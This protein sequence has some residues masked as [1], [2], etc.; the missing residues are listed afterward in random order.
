MALT[1]ATPRDV[2]RAPT[3]PR[4]LDDRGIGPR[5]EAALFAISCLSW[6]FPGSALG[7]RYPSLSHRAS[8]YARERSRLSRL[9]GQGVL[10]RVSGHRPRRTVYG[11]GDSYWPTGARG[12]SP[13][14]DLAVAWGWVRRQGGP[15]GT[16]GRARPGSRDL[17]GRGAR[18]PRVSG[19][20]R[21]RPELGLGFRLPGRAVGGERPGRATGLSGCAAGH[22]CGRRGRS[23]PGERAAALPGG[24][25]WPRRP[26]APPRC[27]RRFRLEATRFWC[28]AGPVIRAAQAEV[29]EELG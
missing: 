26:R 7:A 3:R 28:D 19:A 13:W 16:R 11:A 4:A 14:G 10:R 25:R 8:A 23:R 6:S 12:F 18:S 15:Q 5:A 27:V 17:G 22:R 29:L 2:S 24:P 9:L 21:R 20:R 1:V